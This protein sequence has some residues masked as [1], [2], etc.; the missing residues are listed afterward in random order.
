M[1]ID[2]GSGGYFLGADMIIT[3]SENQTL[4]QTRAIQSDFPV[5][6]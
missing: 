6:K 5:N 4:H 3:L 2:P 1:L